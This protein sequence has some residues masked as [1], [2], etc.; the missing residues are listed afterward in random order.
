MTYRNDH[1]KS[2]LTEYTRAVVHLRS[3]LPLRRLGIIV[4]AGLSKSFK[5]PDWSELVH[6]IAAD[7]AVN[8]DAILRRFS[9]RAS[10]PY[11]TELL[12]QHFRRLQ[13]SR[14]D[15]N[16]VNSLEFENR[17]SA[18]WLSICAKH[19]YK[20]AAGDIRSEL[21]NHP[22]LLNLIPLIQMTQLTVTY[23]FDDY[24]EQ[25][26]AAQRA[27]DDRSRGFETV[28]N[29]WNQFRRQTAVIY[30]PNGI[31]PRDLMDLP[32][33]RFVFSESSFAKQF[34]GNLV[35]DNSFLLTHL[36]KST[37][38]IIGS[39][40]EDETLRNLLIQSAHQNPGNCHYYVHY[41]R[42]GETMDAADR[43][44]IRQANFN[45]YNLVTLF[46]TQSEIAALADLLNPKCF[47][48]DD[49]SDFAVE[50]GR[51]LAYRFYITGPLGVGKTTTANQLQN[52]TVLDEWMVPRP[53]ILAK[54]WDTL[55]DFEKQ[56]ADD[57]IL[58]QFKLKNDVLRHARIGIFIVDRPPLDP[59]VFT[60]EPERSAKA[61]ALLA[62]MCPQDKWEAAEGAVVRM[63]GNPEELSVRVLATGR[64]R[65]DAAKLTRMQED[66]EAVYEGEGV[67]ILDT[68]GM[69]VRDVTKRVTQ[70]I[71]L[72]EY[73]PYGVNARLKHFRG[74]GGSS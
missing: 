62:C 42:D 32:P 37:C 66:L 39:S 69:T 47:D 33:D 11:K 63:I 28:T 34:I 61:K 12:F 29:P 46:L 40:L 51:P 60:A 56:Q 8:G 27:T 10:L 30:H 50:I 43:D 14:F 54:P 53:A 57:W 48:D 68:Q 17:V 25:A 55:T 18:T 9:A 41:V 58:N 64:D 35:G 70:V 36:S 24:L 4:G 31:I 13:A 45:V 21:K 5:L 6:E 74:A 44:A 26:L 7:A 1:H 22:Y 59:L 20:N 16:R 73:T 67:V 38:L 65:Y 71:H 23:N 2:V 52:L 3:Q 15:A 49:L 72:L 19:L